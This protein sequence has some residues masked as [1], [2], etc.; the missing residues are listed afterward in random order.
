M[1]EKSS[2]PPSDRDIFMLTALRRANGQVIGI[3]DALLA[4][5]THLDIKS[6]ARR[7]GEPEDL[8]VT[9]RLAARRRVLQ[10]LGD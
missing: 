9:E 1:R 4:C 8:L 2:S 7:I 3:R 6:L 5:L 10:A